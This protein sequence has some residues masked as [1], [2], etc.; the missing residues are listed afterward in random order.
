MSLMIRKE[1]II[2]I[3]KAEVP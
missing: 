1:K 3:A 2:Q